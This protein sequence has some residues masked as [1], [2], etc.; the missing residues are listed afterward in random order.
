MGI[1]HS[2]HTH[3]IPIPMGIPMEIRIPTA[4]LITRVV[5]RPAL[6][7][8]HFCTVVNIDERHRTVAKCLDFILNTRQR[9]LEIL[10]SLKQHTSIKQYS[11]FHLKEHTLL[12][13]Y[14]LLKTLVK[15]CVQSGFLSHNHCRHWSMTLS[16][17]CCSSSFQTPVRCFRSSSVFHN[18]AP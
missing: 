2:P 11:L 5:Q 4:A 3:T 17:M 12:T 16:I 10:K 14:V 8:C 18:V 1:H 7:F 6:D 15:D 13:N 9:H